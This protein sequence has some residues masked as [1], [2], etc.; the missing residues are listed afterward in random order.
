MRRSPVGKLFLLAFA[1][2][3]AVGVGC[4]LY[5]GLVNEPVLT[6]EEEEENGEDCED[7][8]GLCIVGEC[9]QV[10]GITAGARHSCARL[11]GGDV[12]CWGANGRG[13]LGVADTGNQARPTL[14]DG[15]EAAVAV[16]AGWQHTCAVVASGDALCW[17]D[18][19]ALQLGRT[20]N[21]DW[22][23]RPWPV[24]GLGFVREIAAGYDHTCAIDS[25]G[26][27]FCWGGD[28][29]GQ[30]G[31]GSGD[32]DGSLAVYTPVSVQG[33]SGA[34][35]QAQS[36]SAGWFVSAAVDDAGEVWTWGDNEYGKLGTASVEED[37][38]DSPVKVESLEGGVAIRAGW[39]HVCTIVDSGDLLCWGD[40]QTRQLGRSSPEPHSATPAPV[41]GLGSVTVVHTGW[42]GHSCAG[43]AD[44]LYC[45]GDGEHGQIGDGRSGNDAIAGSATLALDGPVIDVAAGLQHTCAL[46]ATGEV[47]CWGANDRGQ[48]GIGPGF[49]S[50]TEPRRV[51]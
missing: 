7:C 40:N 25:A 35:S 24:T 8:I 41:D 15:V 50:A 34:D 42:G 47:Y 9:R 48:L 10:D 12:A 30:L 16:D 38:V 32:N 46:S 21:E 51:E 4:G 39:R 14:V 22:D 2:C 5:D 36:I 13:Q 45:W 17:G 43:T 33:F 20:T 27:L 29:L 37:S 11:D 49:A 31:R 18:N 23:F 3:T 1:T 28:L 44:G 26:R 6:S 19:D